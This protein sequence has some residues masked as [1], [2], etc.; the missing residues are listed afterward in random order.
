MWGGVPD[1][2]T[3][4]ESQTTHRPRTSP[5]GQELGR[6]L[7]ELSSRLTLAWPFWTL[8]SPHPPG[9]GTSSS[10]RMLPAC[11]CRH[12]PAT[13]GAWL[14][15]R[16][17]VPASLSALGSLTQPSR[18]HAS[19]GL[20]PGHPQLLPLGTPAALNSSPCARRSLAGQEPA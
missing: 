1:R 19:R 3:S 9:P 17:Q 11:L 4:P 20:G 10:L 7:A 13:T 2:G 14:R 6:V 12:P 8:P 5:R 15:G 16:P 18:T